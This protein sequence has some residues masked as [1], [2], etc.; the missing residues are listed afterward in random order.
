MKRFSELCSTLKIWKIV[1]LKVVY[2]LHLERV[3]NFIFY[4]A[5]VASLRSTTRGCLEKVWMWIYR[6]LVAPVQWKVRKKK[7]KEVKRKV[8]WWIRWYVHGMAQDVLLGDS[9]SFVGFLGFPFYS[10]LTSPST[11]S[12]STN[13]LSSRSLSLERENLRPLGRE[14]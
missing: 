10:A 1:K 9:T 8:N 11:V 12:H 13:F 6:C 7:K 4:E 2:K 3:C 5:F 14:S